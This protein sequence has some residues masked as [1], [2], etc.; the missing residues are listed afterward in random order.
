MVSVHRADQLR[1]L[2]PF[3]YLNHSFI[4]SLNVKVCIRFIAFLQILL[5]FFIYQEL[6]WMKGLCMSFTSSCFLFPV[7][8]E[9]GGKSLRT[10]GGINKC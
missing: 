10:G 5:C 2:A 3:S 1:R 8:G 6:C 9:G 4:L 7:R